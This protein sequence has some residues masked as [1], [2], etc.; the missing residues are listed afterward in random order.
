MQRPP[1][2]GDLDASADPYPV[3]R[4]YMIEKPR[5]PPDTPGPADQAAMQA[6]CQHLRCDGTFLVQNIETVAQ[7]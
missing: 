7:E 5:Q 3:M 1:V 2:L 4:Q 6:D